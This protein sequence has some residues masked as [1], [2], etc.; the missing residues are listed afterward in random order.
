MLSNTAWGITFN[1][2]QRRASSYWI[3]CLKPLS[4]CPVKL[5][6]HLG[7]QSASVGGGQGETYHLI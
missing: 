3:S 4:S 1:A 6:M 2:R 5:P 7:E